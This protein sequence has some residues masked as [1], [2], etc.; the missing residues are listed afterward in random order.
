M[1]LQSLERTFTDKVFAVCDYYLVGKMKRN[2]R[3]IYDLY[4]LLPK[5]A[6]T[7]DYKKLVTEIRQHRAKMPICLS[8]QEG[9]DVPSVLEKI[10]EEDVY[11]T[12]YDEITT[13]FQNRPIRYEE[14]VTALRTIIDSGMF[15]S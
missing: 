9:I 2:S 7:E 6:M 15:V 11:K 1:K 5:I 4:M 10:I 3:H 8:A 14:A 13:Y 12:D